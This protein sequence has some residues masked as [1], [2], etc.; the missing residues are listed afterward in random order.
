LLDPVLPKNA[1]NLHTFVNQG[2]KDYFEAQEVWPTG[3][4][5]SPISHF[6]NVASV[7]EAVAEWV[8][9]FSLPFVD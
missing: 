6:V 8:R 1:P 2:S 7:K 3:C 9:F 5:I 4:F